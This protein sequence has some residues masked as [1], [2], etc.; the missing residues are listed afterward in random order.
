MTLDLVENRRDLSPIHISFKNESNGTKRRSQFRS[1]RNHREVE[2][3][4]TRFA[5]TAPNAMNDHDKFYVAALKKDSFSLCRRR[6]EVPKIHK[7]VVDIVRDR[8]CK[9]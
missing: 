1:R 6:A 4:A 2:D 9:V 5:V 7:H 3:S 8:S